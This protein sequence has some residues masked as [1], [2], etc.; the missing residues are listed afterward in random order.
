LWRVGCQDTFEERNVVVHVISQPLR[1]TRH[2]MLNLISHHVIPT[3]TLKTKLLTTNP[4][5]LLYSSWKNGKF[6]LE[7]RDRLWGMKVKLLIEWLLV[8]DLEFECRLSH[9]LSLP[10]FSF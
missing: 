4:T 2:E 7:I 3:K 10:V 8:Q 1:N 6:F 5:T 9:F